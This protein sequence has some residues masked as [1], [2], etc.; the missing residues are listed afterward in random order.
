M[1][2]RLRRHD[3]EYRWIIDHGVP[4]QNLDGGFGGYVGYCFDITERKQAEEKIQTAAEFNQATIDALAAH[5]CVLDENGNILA[6][7]QAWK[8]FALTGPTPARNA[9][10]GANYLAVCDAAGGPEAEDG[11]TFAAGIRAVIAG[12]R[13]VISLEYPCHSPTQEFWFLATVRRF[14]KAIPPRVVITH[15]DIT[16]RKQAEISIRDNEAR[17]RTWFEMPLSGI[18]ITSLE[19]GWLQVNNQLCEMLGYSREELQGM[20]WAQITHPD[21]LEENE[22]KFTQMVHGEADGYAMEKRFLRKNGSYLMTDLTVRCARRADGSPDYIVAL[23]QDI[24]ERKQVQQALIESQE[25]LLTLINSLPD[26]VILKDAGGR[27]L[28]ANPP[29]LRFFRLGS[30]DWQGR[31]DA[32]LAEINPA[33]KGLHN[34]C[35][36]SDEAGWAAKETTQV[37]QRGPGLDGR[38]EEHEVTKVPLFQADGSRKAMLVIGRDVTEK[39]RLKKSLELS[40]L[41]ASQSRDMLMLVRKSDGRICSVNAAATETYGYSHEELLTKTVYDLR[42]EADDASQIAGNLSAAF[43]HGILFETVH[44]RKDGTLMTVEVSSQGFTHDGE[45]YLVSAIRDISERKRIQSQLESQ[46]RFIADLVEYSPIA[47][48]VKDQNGRFLISNRAFEVL[49]G[50]KREEI[51]GHSDVDFFPG[52]PSAQFHENDFK[53]MATGTSQVFEEFL[54][55]EDGQPRTFLTTKFPVRNEQ[56]EITGVCG[57]AME[58]TQIKKTEIALRESEERFRMLLATL[59]IPLAVYDRRETVTFVNLKF[60]ETFGYRQED[61]PTVAAWWQ[62][63]YPDPV[64]RQKVIDLWTA[65]A[66]QIVQGAKNPAATEARV[67]CKDDSCR[68]I[69]FSLTL[70]GDQN[71]VIF[72]DITLRKRAED[73]IKR[74]ATVVEQA[75]E[76]I[77]VTNLAGEIIYVNPAFSTV[78]GYPREEVIGKNPRFL[79]SG[80]QNAKFYHEMWKTLKRGEVWRGHFTNRRK[81]GKL[82]EEDA[83]I[84]PIRDRAGN[85]VSYVASKHDVTREL[86]LEAQ[87][88]QAQKMEAI[89][90]LAGGIAHDFNNILM[91]IFA[92]GG[93]LKNDLAEQAKLRQMADQILK[94][95]NRA[96]DLVQQILTFSRQQE[97]KREIIRLEPVIKEAAKFL[98]ASLPVD[99]KLELSL[100]PDAPTV[101]ADSTQIYQVVMNLATNAVHAMEGK[102]GR[103]T[104][105]LDRFTPD[106]ALLESNPKFQP[107]C[108]ARLTATDTGHGMD[109]KTIERIFEPF[110]TTKGV[111]KGTG[112]GLAVVHGVTQSH[113][114]VITVESELEKGT[115]FS[116]YFPAQK[117]EADLASQSISDL[118]LGNPPANGIKFFATADLLESSQDR[119]W[120]TRMSATIYQHWHKKNMRGK[121][122]PPL[123]FPADGKVRASEAASAS[124]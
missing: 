59:P 72:D 34:A 12:Q 91:A 97:H 16:I 2:Y 38:L 65:Y 19:K 20:T 116:L 28:V 96:K 75:T 42:Q 50:R 85:V 23:I 95:A 77:L 4:F 57:K 86:Q 53:I 6:T 88:R 93:M 80:K 61:L 27:W 40:N 99:I 104:I 83:V 110:F 30:I 15:E 9:D 113:D 26:N 60:T 51:I 106:Q 100:S 66:N 68:D 49:I 13:E 117:L 112:L 103:L 122:V 11:R 89:G 118:P 124:G 8:R 74:L 90:T 41:M 48:F 78:T 37:V 101:L 123:T 52:K 71:L 62:K 39:S 33:L 105:G 87:F 17:L 46:R 58:I 44:R 107:I 3:G 120:L 10:V 21:D 45:H 56:G 24:T 102:P 111:G 79:K 43:A 92:Y 119:Q 25:N 94:S 69:R 73:E 32:E 115:S 63:A 64:Y 31:T 81:D 29:A 109:A 54:V 7:N 47:V 35:I 1:E 84:S 114:A 108:Y 67:T 70:A 98:R 18:A 55:D 121:L 82:Y 14:E 22:A 36:R 5:L 76:A